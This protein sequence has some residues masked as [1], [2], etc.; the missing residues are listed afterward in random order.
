M[1]EVTG[2]CNGECPGDDN[3]TS[4]SQNRRLQEEPKKVSGTD[5]YKSY[6]QDENSTFFLPFI[7]SNMYNFDNMTLSLNASHPSNQFTQYDTHSLNGLLEAWRTRAFLTNATHPKSDD[8]TFMLSRS[9]FAGAGKYTQHWLGDNHRTFDDMKYSIAGV[10]N[11]NMF[12]IPLVG[13]D[14]CGFFDQGSPDDDQICG[15][16][17]QLATFYPFARQHRD[18][19]GGGKANEPYNLVEPYQ[20]M[21]KNALYDRLQYVR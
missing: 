10:M 2:F 11:F 7:P 15:R 9:T 17:I 19:T 12:G 1:N 16:W 14:T 4:T 21:A 6:S 8:R 3:T 18:D 20:S 5:W 13:P